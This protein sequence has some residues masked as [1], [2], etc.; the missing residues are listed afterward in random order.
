MLSLLRTSFQIKHCGLAMGVPSRFAGRRQGTSWGS[1]GSVNSQCSP[2]MNPLEAD[3]ISTYSLSFEVLKI[4]MNSIYQPDD[5]AL[6]SAQLAVM[7]VGNYPLYQILDF[8]N[9]A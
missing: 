2:W 8:S 5:T 7:P 9:N 4:Q 3:K 1:R 6:I